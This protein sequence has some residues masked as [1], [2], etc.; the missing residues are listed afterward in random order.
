VPFAFIIVGTV[1][2]ISGVKGTSQDLLSLVKGDL[3]G[4]NNFVYW[5][6]AIL[7]VGSIGYIPGF[8]K[9]SIAFLSLVLIVLF[10]KEGNPNG[11]G[12]GF[13]QEFQNS[14]SQI[15]KA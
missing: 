15:T 11:S 4:S 6:I 2:L 10:L 3:T 14:I 12:G 7:V 9:F 5:I 1:L 13:F 8:R